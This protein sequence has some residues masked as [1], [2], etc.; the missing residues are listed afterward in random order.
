MVYEAFLL[1]AVIFMSALLFDV[2][3]S[4]RHALTLRHARMAWV[5]FAIGLYFCYFWTRG[6]QTLAM[7]T[8]RIQ[9]LKKDGGPV[10]GKTAALRYLGAWMWFFPALVVDAVFHLQ[11]WPS[12]LA[13][14]IGF[15]VW[16]CLVYLDQER[17]FMHDKLAGTRLVLLPKPN[18]VESQ[19]E[20]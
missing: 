19:A 3:T 10:D 14:A 20:A 7:K 6:G 18:A 1:F 9:L 8:W 15:V 4:S 16:A 11:R 13:I 17:H 12:V 2:L 5:F